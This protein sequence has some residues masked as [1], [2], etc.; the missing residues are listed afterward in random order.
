MN[1][2]TQNYCTELIANF[3]KNASIAPGSKIAELNLI[4]DLACKRAFDE[5]R[6]E[7]AG[8]RS[9]FD[10]EAIAERSARREPPAEDI[11]EVFFDF[12]GVENDET[13]L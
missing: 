3:L 4:F 6:R 1:Q 2:A 9:R 12:D 13:G 8:E 10:P 7:G 11:Q 5:G